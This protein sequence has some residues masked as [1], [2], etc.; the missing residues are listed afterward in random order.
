MDVVALSGPEVSPEALNAH[1]ATLCTYI[2]VPVPYVL[3]VN[4]N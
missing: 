2:G 4:T 1:L 3:A